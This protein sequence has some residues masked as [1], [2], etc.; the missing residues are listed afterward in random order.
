MVC[1]DLAA[2][3]AFM[4]SHDLQDLADKIQHIKESLLAGTGVLK[5][6]A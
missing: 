1:P 6:K 2:P 3:F 5:A 4:G